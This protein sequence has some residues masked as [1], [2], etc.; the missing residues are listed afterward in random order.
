MSAT[1]LPLCKSPPA[2]LLRRHRSPPECRVATGTLTHMT[3]SLH[4]MH[5]GDLTNPKYKLEYYMKMAEEIVEQ[6]CH[7]IGTKDMAGLLKPRAA[8]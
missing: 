2:V 6:G 7:A 8:M 3:A 4:R 5:A 1:T